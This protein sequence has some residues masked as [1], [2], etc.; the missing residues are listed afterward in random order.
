LA[1]Q[2]G[3]GN[4]TSSNGAGGS[5]SS[6][7][8]PAEHADMPPSEPL[9][10]FS[11]LRD[12]NFR[13]LWLGQI[14]HAGALWMEQIARPFLILDITDGSA[15]HVGG[16]IAMR[17]LPQLI[18]G[19]WAGVVADWFDRR[20]VL[21]LDK[22][23]VLILNT[24][25]ALLLVF[26]VLE[27]WHIYVY[28]FFRGSLM[29]FDQP[30]RSALIPS[31]VPA[32]RV[33]NA[34]ALMSATQNAMRIAGASAGGF[35]YAAV[36]AEGA[37]ITVAVIYIGAVVSTYLLKVP[38]HERPKEKGMGAMA[39][40]LMEGAR[41]AWSHTAIRGI[42]IL[43]LVYFTFGMSYMQVFAP[44]FAEKVLDIGSFGF[45][46]MTSLTGIGALAAALFIANKQPSRLGIILPLLA[47][48]FGL[49][50]ILFSAT[51]YL[52]QPAG[53]I[54]PLI[55]IMLVGAIQTSYFSLTRA[56]M[57]H[58][59]PEEMR[60]RVISLLSLDRA[61]MTGGAA[62][63]GFLADIVGVQLAQ[64]VYGVICAAGGF[65]MFTFARDFRRTRTEFTP[66]PEDS[67]PP[68][69]SAA[70]ATAETPAD[71]VSTR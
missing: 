6:E 26:G 49:M 45:G 31:I 19:V 38:T 36:G 52:P 70:G 53:L 42:L 59:A 21:L 7:V 9:G 32:D 62:F 33:T 41:Y 56:M 44:L 47:G 24:M 35:V 40:G 16:V 69:A 60:G 23:A 28:A 57:L 34:I 4:G 55:V 71:I 22:T 43:S 11:A 61:L 2:N 54:A 64:I 10:T 46:F 3:S 25:F 67:L 66:D 27:L 8:V 37:F 39:S 20:L 63:A 48:V 65:A 50:L 30:A 12:P 17:T 68:S 29:A 58:S 15:T 5:E 13:F 1:Q 51:T 18:F 14:S